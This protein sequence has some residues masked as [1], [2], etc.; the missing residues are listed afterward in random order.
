MSAKEEFYKN[1]KTHE[2]F[3]LKYNPLNNDVTL[4]ILNLDIWS[5][6]V[7]QKKTFWVVDEIDLSRD[8][9]DFK[10]QNKDFQHF[11]KN[12]LAFFAASDGIVTKNL[13]TRFID[14][15]QDIKECQYLYTFQAMM[16]NIHSEMYSELIANIIPNEDEQMLLFNAVNTMPIIKKKADWARKWTNDKDSSYGE[17][18]I[19]FICVEGIFFSGSFASIFWIKERGI[20]PGLTKS[21]EFIS[22]DEGRH[23]N[24]GIKMYNKLHVKIPTESVH[25]IFKEAVELEKEFITESIPC[26][27]IGMNS[28]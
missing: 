27:M 4:P 1:V 12:I 23:T 17:R 8:S 11:V 2:L 19:A 22:R 5:E 14:D 28:I 16:E 24:A 20:M 18:V 10:K 15:V 21:N 9:N 25:A 13:N 26:S 6:Y 7:D 3:N